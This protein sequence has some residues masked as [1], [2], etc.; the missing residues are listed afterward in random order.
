MPAVRSDK[1]LEEAFDQLTTR[2]GFL[3]NELYPELIDLRRRVSELEGRVNAVQ[4]LAVIDT[5]GSTSSQ[6]PRSVTL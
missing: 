4:G 1:E 2:Y 6:P 3:H 5:P